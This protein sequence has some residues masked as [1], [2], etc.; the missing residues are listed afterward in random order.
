M[1][2]TLE[3]HQSRSRRMLRLRSSKLAGQSPSKDKEKEKDEEEAKAKDK[4]FE[5]EGGKGKD[6]DKAE[7][8]RVGPEEKGIVE[9]TAKIGWLCANEGKPF[10]W[11]YMLSLARALSRSES[12]SKE[13]AR[14]LR[15]E[16]K[17]AMPDAQKRAARVWAILALNASDYFRLQIATKR[18][19]EVVDDIIKSSKT[20]PPVK[21]GVLNA[22]SVLAYEFHTDKELSSITKLYNKHRPPDKPINGEG[23][24]IQSKEF[25]PPPDASLRIVRRQARPQQPVIA[26]QQIIPRE[27]DIR[28]LHEECSIAVHNSQLLVDAL[29]ADPSQPELITE[30]SDKLRL[31]Q[32][33]LLAQIPWASA[34]AEKAR[35]DAAQA[36]VQHVHEDA[37]PSAGER[38]LTDEEEL[39]GDLL[40][41]NE[42]MNKAMMLLRTK[43]RDLAL[44]DH[45]V[46][47]TFHEV[48][49]RSAPQ[50][51]Q[52]H[53]EQLR[54]V[55][56]LSSPQAQLQLQQQ[57]QEQEQEEALSDQHVDSALFE[58]LVHDD[59]YR[60][61]TSQPS[62][63]GHDRAGSQNFSLPSGFLDFTS[64]AQAPATVPALTPAEGLAPTQSVGDSV[65]PVYS[66]GSLSTSHGLL[67]LQTMPTPQQPFP[68][69]HQ[70]SANVVAARASPWATDTFVPGQQSHD[71]GQIRSTCNEQGYADVSIG[72]LSVA[73]PAVPVYRGGP[74]P[75][76]G[77]TPSA[78]PAPLTSSTLQSQAASQSLAA[79]YELQAVPS[80]ELYREQPHMNPIM[81]TVLPSGN[82][83]MELGHS[84]ASRPPPLPPISTDVPAGAP[85]VASPTA[86]DESSIIETPLYPSEK[87]LGKRRAISICADSNDSRSGTQEKPQPHTHPRPPQP[88]P[89]NG[90]S[91]G[92]AGGAPPEPFRDNA[93]MDFLRSRPMPPII[94]GAT[95]T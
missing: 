52:S 24:N 41:A 81:Q 94:A 35:D 3:Q 74:R 67:P 44:A 43:H 1:S 17:Y 45:A 95:Q 36:H 25:K 6:K 38:V 10:E 18:F 21:G 48:N 42:H 63:T 75:F 40:D 9:V 33:F 71:Y 46:R 91:A 37:D 49:S 77:S 4:S 11:A 61:A 8:N 64:S 26:Q 57:E 85:S 82:T 69:D 62:L 34:E 93:Y 28:K 70:P 86:S 5:K 76:P 15:K 90:G 58:A 68:A 32:E 13:A 92:S 59:R 78:N 89:Y 51:F 2:E 27:V 50:F 79:P 19:L 30:F 53:N 66:S 56:V 39:L 84:P 12:A 83:G 60:D 20:P 54:Q 14:A 16:F 87:A 22:L 7:E 72:A 29:T 80:Q 31:S 88:Y 23:L 47:F 65:Q 55:G 73:P